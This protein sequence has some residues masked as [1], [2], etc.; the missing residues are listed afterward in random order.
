MTTAD[1]NQLLISGHVRR[2]PEL[3]EARRNHGV[4]TKGLNWPDPPGKGLKDGSFVAI[5]DGDRYLLPFVLYTYGRIE[6]QFQYMARQPPFDDEQL[7]EQLRQR[8]N[9][10]DDTINIPAAKLALRPSIPLDVLS[11][12]SNLDEFLAVLNWAF[13]QPLQTPDE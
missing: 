9:A 3:R 5:R 7:R 10:I 4:G 1:L 6:I 8:L 2:Q 11:H 12:R 13:E